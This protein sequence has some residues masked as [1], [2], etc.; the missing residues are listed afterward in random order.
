MKMG[1]AHQ[2][3]LHF[4]E[5]AFRIIGITRHQGFARQKAE[6]RIA[7]E[8]E[9]FVVRG[10]FRGLLVYS[11]LVSKRPLKQLPVLELVTEN[12]FDNLELSGDRLVRAMAAWSCS[13]D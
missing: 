12:V 2:M 9:L 4:R 5:T 7:Q 13:K 1:G 11:R 6:N 10:R 3:R 8:F